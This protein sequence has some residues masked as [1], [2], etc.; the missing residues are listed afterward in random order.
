VNQ[1]SISSVQYDLSLADFRAMT[2][3]LCSPQQLRSGHSRWIF[4]ASVG[5]VAL[6]ATRYHRDGLIFLSGMFVACIGLFAYFRS[7]QSRSQAL[8]APR[9]NGYVLCHYSLT[10]SERG[11]GVTTPYWNGETRWSGVIAADETDQHIFLQYD[12]T[13]ASVIPKSAFA[14]P[15]D[16]ARFLAYARERMSTPVS[17]ISTA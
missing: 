9:Q 5:A 6:I 12:T 2:L 16:A 7:V 11:V 17:T 10:L 3:H 1:P 13:A 14:T 4:L 8:C 15:A